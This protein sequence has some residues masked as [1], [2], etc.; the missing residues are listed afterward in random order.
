MDDPGINP[1]GGAAISAPSAVGRATWSSTVPAVRQLHP[2][3][4]DNVD[5][6]TIYGVDPRPEHPDRP[7]LLLDMVSS[8][9][10][11]TAVGPVSRPL[12]S[13]ADQQVFAVLRGL[14]D[15]ILVGAGTVRAERYGPPKT[16]PE[17]QEERVLR[18][19]SPH[20]RIAI[21]SLS[22][23]L[24]LDAPLFVESDPA[25]LVIT[26]PSASQ[27][28]R[29]EVANRA[30]L[31]LAGQGGGVD[32]AAALKSLHELG[33]RV[34]VCEGGPTLNG[35]LLDAGLVDE[36]CVTIAPALAGGD[37]KRMVAS[38]TESVRELEL[39]RVLEHEG[40]LFL[41]YTLLNH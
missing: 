26:A 22:L 34:V 23:D 4:H 14:A 15:V 27:A 41:R 1:S 38:A 18:G 39:Q 5:P 11:G 33:A 32:L 40:A 20:P 25:P 30:D 29:T 17:V 12:S 37:S 28:R 3:L 35:A 31:L 36:V 24:S 9:D 10:G 2:E 6:A 21:V 13:P 8:V 16:P 7:W 19:Q